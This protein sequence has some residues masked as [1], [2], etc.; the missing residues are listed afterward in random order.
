MSFNPAMHGQSP[1]S[2]S[3]D[4]AESTQGTPDTRFTAF[5]PEDA[6][7]FKLTA[8]ASTATPLRA[9]QHDPFVTTTSKSKAEQ[10]LSATASS[11]QP[12]SFKVSSA[13]SV[14]TVAYG[15]ASLTPLLSNPVP[16]TVQYL[17]SVVAAHTSPA[18][19]AKHTGATQH[20]IFTTD[21]GA[22]RCIKVASIYQDDVLPL[23]NLSLDIGFS[24]RGSKRIEVI[25]N[26]VYLRLSNINE[27]GKVYTAIKLDHPKC[28]VEYISAMT[29]GKIV[30][31][32][33]K[34]K[35]SAHEGQVVLTAS[36]P[37]NV[38]FDT[39]EFE[40]SLRA[41]LSAEGELHAWQ[42]LLATEA[43]T[44]RMVAEFMDAAMA[45]RAVQRCHGK[46][47]DSVDVSVVMHTPDI[48]SPQVTT[49]GLAPTI[50]PTRRSGE[51]SDISDILGQMSLSAHQTP[52]YPHNG[53]PFGP[54]V[55]SPSALSYMTTNSPYGLPPNTL[56]VVMN[57][58]YS[59]SPM[60]PF[61]QG[62]SSPQGHHNDDSFNG[63]PSSITYNPAMFA[64]NGFRGGFNHQGFYSQ[65]HRQDFSYRPNIPST[66]YAMAQY[67][68]H[69]RRQNNTRG[70]HNQMNR[71]R[72]FNNPAAGH[73]NHVDIN[74]IRQGIDVR[75][76][77]MLRNIPNKVD[78]AMLKSIVDESSHGKYDFM[79]LRIDFSNNCNVGY[80]FINFTDR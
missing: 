38:S 37:T 14:P 42:K 71:S 46:K 13:S 24:I 26:V 48:S 70:P 79:Y 41:L 55:A 51:Q 18:P 2:S 57:G 44:F 73:H 49:Y 50:T 34:A 30:T 10:K 23:V 75:T 25:G 77:V 52:R 54:S 16:G 6:R 39:K 80:A 32:N 17:D 22:T 9:S 78:Q 56:P 27:A 28:A 68:R 29:F 59:P 76:T 66:P 62:Y 47:I 65:A 74:R 43:G 58:M 67:H 11:F 33:S 21:T 12:F 36:Y 53:D 1:H 5:S 72:N 61:P 15:S 35:Y 60:V 64:Q 45:V 7:A 3:N 4:A 19:A 63:F 8:S 69:G 40:E 20:G 31:P